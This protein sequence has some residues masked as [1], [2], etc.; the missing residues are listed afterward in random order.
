M[1]FIQLY[2][3]FLSEDH[4]GI[5]VSPDNLVDGQLVIVARADDDLAV[6][7]YTV[8]DE[9]QPVCNGLTF[10]S[11]ED[12]LPVLLI[13]GNTVHLFWGGAVG[14]IGNH[15]AFFFEVRDF[16]LGQDLGLAVESSI[17]LAIRPLY[18]GYQKLAGHIATDDQSIQIEVLGGVE[19]FPPHCL[20]AVEIGGEEKL[21]L[22]H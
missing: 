5:R 6:R 11:L 19:E 8:W 22:G 10:T 20:G 3:F 18:D 15:A 2:D 14:D 13:F 4:L 17:E 12:I 7:G 16:V 9:G 21:R 1:L